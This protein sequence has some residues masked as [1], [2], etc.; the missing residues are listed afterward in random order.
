VFITGDVLTF[1]TGIGNKSVCSNLC[2]VNKL[3]DLED[4]FKDGDIIVVKSSSNEILPYMRRASGIIAEQSGTNSHA[5]IVGYALDI[6]VIVG[7]HGA[8]H[9]L[10]SN[11]TVTM[12][13]TKGI[14]HNRTI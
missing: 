5:A 2:V 6:P 14:V 1:G 12:D 10:K 9:V 7:A 8:L 11:T 3:K 4:R 13:A